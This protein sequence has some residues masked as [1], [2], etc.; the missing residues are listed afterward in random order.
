MRQIIN[1]PLLKAPLDLRSGQNAEFSNPRDDESFSPR[2]RTEARRD[3]I[4]GLVITVICLS[5]FAV[6]LL[7]GNLHYMFN[8][9]KLTMIMLYFICLLGL[10]AIGRLIATPWLIHRRMARPILTSPTSSVN[11]YLRNVANAE[12]NSLSYSCLSPDCRLACG[13][14]ER[15]AEIWRGAI[16]SFKKVNQ[17]VEI[18]RAHV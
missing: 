5:P 8:H 12:F 11:E 13:G 6:I 4:A 14:Q 17:D 10:Y 3:I 15:F 1:L 18:G 16:K 7:T 9:S 2:L